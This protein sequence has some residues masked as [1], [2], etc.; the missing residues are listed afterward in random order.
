MAFK[1]GLEMSPVRRKFPPWEGSRLHYP[2]HG[3]SV[4]KEKEII[5]KKRYTAPMSM[6]GGVKEKKRKEK[7]RK[8]PKK[9]RRLKPATLRKSSWATRSN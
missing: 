3:L 7:K 4:R 6:Y 9:I 2:L 1:I 5:A 8:D